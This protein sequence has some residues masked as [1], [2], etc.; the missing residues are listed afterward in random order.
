MLAATLSPS[1]GIYSGFE[2]LEATP[3]APGSEE[4]LDSEKY[5]LK[6]AEARR[7]AAAA[8]RAAERD[9]PRARPV[10][11]ARQPHVPRDRERPADRLREAGGRD[12]GRSSASTSTRTARREGFVERAARARASADRFDVTDLLTGETLVVERPGGN[13]VRLV[14]G[15]RQAHVCVSW[16]PTGVAGQPVPARRDAGTGRERTSRS[17]P[18]TPSA[19]SSASS[20]RTGNETRHELPRRTAFNWHGYLPGVGP[21]ARYG[22][23]VHGPYDPRAAT[24]ST[25]R[26]S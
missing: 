24:A 18:S 23:R 6:A 4:Y 11:P 3:V 16:S 14:P 13:Y 21:G 26:S 2:N 8:R 7:G 15:E 22:Y 20:T 12:D 5:E 19:S 25:P 9:P 1:Y 17:S 10:P